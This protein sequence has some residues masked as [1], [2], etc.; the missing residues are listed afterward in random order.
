MAQTLGRHWNEEGSRFDTCK[1]DA[2]R[3][4]AKAA[5]EWSEGDPLEPDPT[6]IV[7]KMLA[8]FVDANFLH[9]PYGRGRG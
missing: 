3:I 7:E 1:Q 9:P 8:I 6:E 2:A 4:L 5:N